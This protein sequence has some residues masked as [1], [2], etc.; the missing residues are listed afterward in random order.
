M[1]KAYWYMSAT[2]NFKKAI[3]RPHGFQVYDLLHQLRYSISN[4]VHQLGWQ[5]IC[6]G[7]LFN[8]LNV[9]KRMKEQ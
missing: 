4:A 9:D 7:Y 5:A 2:A 6:V 8:Y 3:L 1:V